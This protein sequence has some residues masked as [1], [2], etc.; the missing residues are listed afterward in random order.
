[1][2][3]LLIGAMLAATITVPVSAKDVV[4]PDVCEDAGELSTASMIKRQE[5]M[6]LAVMMTTVYGFDD[7]MQP[8]LRTALVIDADS[9]P[10]YSVLGNQ[11]DAVRNFA[12][13]NM[14]A[15]YLVVTEN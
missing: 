11:Q 15:C 5:N 3:K 14:T 12:N 13:K 9:V 10:R 4:K 1:M 2:K 6:D 7:S 8:K